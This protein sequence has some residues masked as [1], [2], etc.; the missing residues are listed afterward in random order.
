MVDAV[1]VTGV[2]AGVVESR[3]TPTMRGHQC[4]DPDVID[5]PDVVERRIN[6]VV[7]LTGVRHHRWVIRPA[8]LFAAEVVGELPVVMR[9]VIAEDVAGPRPIEERR[10]ALDH[11]EV[12]VDSLGDRETDRYGLAA[13]AQ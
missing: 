6:G 2:P 10:R 3:A 4:P 1:H 7:A 5:R 12:D 9:R 8:G 11:V 13:I